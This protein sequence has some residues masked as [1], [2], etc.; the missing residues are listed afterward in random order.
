MPLI[1]ATVVLAVIL[2]LFAPRRV[3]LSVTALAAAATVFAFFWATLDGLGDDPWWTPLV[4]LAGAA[5]AM[6][7]CY[8]LT[9]KRVE[10]KTA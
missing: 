9:T 7:V 3:A 8:W 4:G 2:G 10:R 6:G 5:F 1:V